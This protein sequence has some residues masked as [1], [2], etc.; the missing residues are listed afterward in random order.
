MK[1]DKI[2]SSFLDF[3][4]S[5]S[6]NIVISDTLIPNDPTLLFTS[7]GMNQFKDQFMGKNV[8]FKKVASCQKCFRTGDLDKVGKTNSHHTFF[9]MLGNFSFGDYF[10]HEAIIWAWEYFT[11]V[12]S[13][14][15]DSLWASV[16]K[17]DEEAYNI[18]KDEIKLPQDKIIRLGAKDNFWPSDVQKNGPNGPCGPCSE[19]FY[20][21]GDEV[22]CGK[23]DCDPSCECGRFIEVW[24]LVFTQHERKDDGSLE[25]LP[26]KNIDTGM[27]L[28]RL[29][30]VMQGVR[31]NFEIDIFKPIID[32]IKKRA[33]VPEGKTSSIYAIADHIRA[34]VFAISD[35]IAPSSDERGYVVRKLISR[36]ISHGRQIGIDGYFLASL[37]P[38]VI[39]A[40]G[41]AYPELESRKEDI[42]KI[43]S[44][45]EEKRAID[46]K[47]KKEKD[48]L[49]LDIKKANF[50]TSTTSTSIAIV[51]ENV[52]Y[53]PD[54]F[55]AYDSLGVPLDL[56]DEVAKENNLTIDRQEFD[57]L[58][59]HQVQRSRKASKMEDSIFV[60][61][62]YDLSNLAKTEFKGYKKDK[63]KS[64]VLGVIKD[65]EFIDIACEGDRALLILNQTPFYA[66]SGGQVTDIG[67]ILSSG[68]DIEV[69]NV[70]NE[71]DVYLHDVKVLKG[72]VKKQDK[73][74]A[75]ID[76]VRRRN[77]E[78][79]H[80]AT[81]ILHQALRDVLGTHVKQSGSL[82]DAD[83]LRFDFSHVKALSNDEIS[84]VEKLV[85]KKIKEGKLTSQI[86]KKEEAQK[87]GALSFFGDKYKEDVRVIS[88]SDFSKEFCG[89]THVKGRTSNIGSFKI[90][91]ESSVASG[92]RRIEAI[93]GK[94][95]DD[96]I[97]SFNRIKKDLCETLGVDEENI[98]SS[99][100]QKLDLIKSLNNKIRQLSKNTWKQKVD[101][102]LN[103]ADD[104]IGIKVVIYKLPDMGMDGLGD[105]LDLITKNSKFCI[106]IIG[107]IYKDKALLVAGVTSDLAN[108]GYDADLIIKEVASIIGAKGGGKKTFA[109]AGGGNPASL[110]EALDKSKKIISD[111]IKDHKG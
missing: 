22:G 27:G 19:I 18:W 2:R 36:A 91:S 29:A 23:T 32:E 52:L 12:L 17:N 59:Q 86:L 62:K 109:Q 24:N 98:I 15:P 58:M 60:S 33:E 93:T 8:S 77:I 39:K 64:K 48:K 21:Q 100:N 82:V 35:G 85:N 37:V 43:I 94:N 9:E 20:D 104:I 7:A 101:E 5:K 71:S 83:R 47:A 66:E 99:I 68:L 42:I 88:V 40:M 87:E 89:G 106:A 3:F 1:T 11:K 25:D 53:G 44:L 97:K 4:K 92:I 14:N 28:E 70:I 84:K 75:L 81:H 72:E 41:K 102:L 95:A 57:K 96:Y 110:D 74:K 31:N 10:K 30:A 38:S 6:H 65:S 45:E 90:I 46:I 61:G 56:I 55:R 79:N 108:Q 69:I 78:R 16:Y 13:L 76:S 63:T 103:R 107:S 49:Y 73:V 111:Y 80:T 54:V 34:V 67:K 51:N 50:A 105:F 26:T